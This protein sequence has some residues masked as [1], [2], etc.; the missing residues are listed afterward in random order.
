MSEGLSRRSAM[1]LFGT[2]GVAL[3]AGGCAATVPPGSGVRGPSPAAASVVAAR[4]GSAARI[5]AL[6]DQLTLDEKTA[7]LHGARDPAALGQA[8]YLPGVPRLG[9]PALR[10]ADGPAGVRV[11]KPATALPAPV[12]LASAFDPGLAREYGRVLG[13]EG[14]A[15]GQDVLLAP[16]VNLIRTPYA[17]RNFET[18]SEDPGL[19]ADLAA[20]L[21]RGIQD[22]GLIATVKHFVLS[23]QE[24]GRDTIDVVADEQTL[25][26]TELRGFEAAITAGA[27]A[28]MGSYNKVNGTYAC[29]SKQLLD[30]LLRGGWGFDGWVVSDWDA[31]HS[32]VAAI[33]AGLDVEMPDGTHFGAPLRE[34]VRAGSVPEEAVDLAARR[35]LTTMDRFGLL[36]GRPTARPARDASAGARVARR[37]A[38]AGAVLLR[39]ENATLP[40]TGAAARSIAVIG[41]TGQV[42]FVSGG[43]SAHVV[44]DRAPAPL[45]AIRQRAGNG[46]T[47]RYALGEDVYGR[48]LPVNLLAPAADLDDRVIGPGRRWSHEGAFS[49]P[50]DD[51]WTLVVHYTGKRPEVRLD[52]EELFPVRQGVAE[53][54]A[55]GLLGTAPDGRAVRRRTLALAAGPHRLAVTAEGGEEGQRFRLRH[56]TKASRAADLAEAVKIA[57]AA[58]SV[59]L[60]A[61]EDATEGRD[62]TSLELPGGQS[63]LIEEVAAANPRTAVVLNT[64]SSTV[65]PWLSRTGAVLQMYY[66]GQEGAGAT[67]DILFGDVDPGGRLT[68]TF[69]ADERATPV[70]GDPQR[71]PG[72]GGRQEYAEGVHVGHRWYDAQRVAPLFPFGHGL[73]YTTWEYEKLS[74]RPEHRGLRVE[75]TVRNTGR[76]KGTEVAQVYVGPSPELKLDQP[77]RVLAGYRRLTLAPGEAQRVVLDIDARTLSSWDPAEHAWVLGSGRREVFAGRSSRDLPLKAKAVVRSR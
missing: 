40:L 12:L 72:V 15:L 4:P 46:A 14:R 45:T 64:S 11:A 31:T 19:T 35:V 55:G 33:N 56:A 71:Y 48:P 67:A 8:G 77:V 70:G 3:A 34:A 66:P 22:E 52:G 23:N 74:V 36:T 41:P 50:A 62:R 25:R 49:L 63:R 47:V 58:R 54:F 30:E 9:I 69:P 20:E 29:E 57:K 24:Q 7:L 2:V 53:Y 68:Q 21:V 18:F 61:Y 39:N 75:F 60:F 5:D 59:V 44:P 37:V 76:R 16:M 38:T 6:L 17:G 73:S 26:E 42:P 32:T 1:R 13:R 27:G 51:E 43:G 10:F 65:M 28:V